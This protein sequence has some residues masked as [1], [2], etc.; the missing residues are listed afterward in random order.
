MNRLGFCKGEFSQ[1][2]L[3]TTIPTTIREM[4]AHPR[5]D[6]ACLNYRVPV[7]AVSIIPALPKIT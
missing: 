3:N 4:P 1:E 5:V 2:N 6:K 7:V